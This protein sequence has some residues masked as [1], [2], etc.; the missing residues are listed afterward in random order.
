MS[1]LATAIGGA[2]VG[3]IISSSNQSQ[4]I[5]NAANAQER[6]ANAGVDETRRQFDDIKKLLSPYVSAGNNSLSSQLDLLGLN[7]PDAEKSAID[8][9]QSG[10]G[11]QAEV[12]QGEN[13]ILQN[14]SA[15]GGLRG[16]NLQA[17]LAQFRPQML[18]R[19][20]DSQFNKLGGITNLG[21]SSAAG[22]GA[23][24]QQ[25]GRDIATLLE[26]SGAA[27]AGGYLSQ[28]KNSANM[29]GDL[30]GAASLPLALKVG[31]YKF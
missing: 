19:A 26:Q 18:S 24:G 6:A 16:G 15:T 2:A 12:A 28:G 25:T 31:G 23:A 29:W 8:R 30:S 22:V 5:G 27:E 17:L 11:F 10:E 1:W 14:A 9:I 13:A 21:Q 20:I 4:A 7:G 3:S